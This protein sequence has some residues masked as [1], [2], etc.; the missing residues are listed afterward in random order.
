[1]GRACRFPSKIA[2]STSILSTRWRHLYAYMDSLDVDSLNH[3]LIEQFRLNLI[4]TLRISDSH[5]CGWISVAV[6]C[7][8]K[9]IDLV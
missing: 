4:N 7:G 1:M 5:V 9:E 3:I 8:V 6:W 2:V